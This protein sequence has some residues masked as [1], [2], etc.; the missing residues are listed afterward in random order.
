MLSPTPKCYQELEDDRY[1]IIFHLPNDYNASDPKNIQTFAE[2][3][4]KAREEYN[5]ERRKDYNK[6]INPEPYLNAEK[7]SQKVLAES[8]GVSAM[9]ISNYEN[10]KIKEVPLSYIRRL[11]EYLRVTPH[12]L[13]GLVS[14][15]AQT[16]VLDENGNRVKAKDKDGNEVDAVMEE[17][18]TFAPPKTISANE[19]YANLIV[20]DHELYWL[21]W[22]LIKCPPSVR[23]EC[24]IKLR[25]IIPPKYL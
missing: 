9:Q 23:K 7:M 22:K 17:A 1:E 15:K 18:M 6:P 14:D 21:I 3:L 24:K 20:E 2:R 16:L 8:I 11:C 25:E 19:D 10:G 4:R 13:L 5:S 12:Y